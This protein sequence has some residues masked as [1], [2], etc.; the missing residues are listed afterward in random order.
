MDQRAVVTECCQTA[1]NQYALCAEKCTVGYA[2]DFS[3]VGRLVDAT[4]AHD[5]PVL[6]R[7]EMGAG[8]DAT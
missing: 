4:E 2:E 5:D 7:T 1:L 8:H 3:R 6:A